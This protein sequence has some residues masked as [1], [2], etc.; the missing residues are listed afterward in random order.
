MELINAIALFALVILSVASVFW[1]FRVRRKMLVFL[2]EF[3]VKLEEVLKPKDKVYTL[4]GYLVGYKATYKLGDGSKAYIL[5]TTAPRLSLFYYPIAKAL[6][7]E[8][9]VSIALRPGIER[10]VREMHAVREGESR[11]KAVLSR[12]LGEKLNKLNTTKVKTKWGTYEVFYEDPK[13]VDILLGVINDETLP[14]YKV[15]AYKSLNLTEIV[16]KAEVDKVEHLY[17]KLR[18]FTSK[19]AR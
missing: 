5:L 19:V 16:S 8:D 13:D 3:T 6:G 14:I 18:E 17:R 1:Y 4:L 12:D 9:R 2:K 15:S 7:R 10:I 11:L